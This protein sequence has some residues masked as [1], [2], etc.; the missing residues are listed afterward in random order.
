MND[1]TVSKAHH[2]AV[3]RGLSAT[4]RAQ[5]EEIERLRN[6]CPGYPGGT[7]EHCFH[8]KQGVQECCQCDQ[9]AAE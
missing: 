9:Q 6:V 7:E 1:Q 5:W 2:E 8:D 4:I 3:V